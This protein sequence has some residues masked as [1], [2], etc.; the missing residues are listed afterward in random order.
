MT[1]ATRVLPGPARGLEA[2][3]NERGCRGLHRFGPA[4]E[5]RARDLPDHRDRVPDRERQVR[6][7]QPRHRRRLPSRRGAGGAARHQGAVAGQD[8]LLRPLPLRHGLQGRPAVLP[9]PEEGRTAPGDPDGRPVRHMPPDGLRLLEA[10]RLRRRNGR[11]APRRRL[12]GIDRDRHGGR[13]DPAPVPSPTRR[14]PRSSTTSR[15]PTR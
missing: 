7:L 2:A 1:L 15:S 9:R 11:R 14:R 10:P 3:S 4:P 6:Q 13:G 8:R 5:P 12:L